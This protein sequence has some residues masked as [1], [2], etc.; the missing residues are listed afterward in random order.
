MKTNHNHF[1]VL[2]GVRSDP[3]VFEPESFE[4]LFEVGGK[5]LGHAVQE[6]H[7]AVGR[8]QRR[9]EQARRFIFFLFLILF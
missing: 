1:W 9:L 5:I 6:L 3:V 4:R 2:S 7:L 8:V